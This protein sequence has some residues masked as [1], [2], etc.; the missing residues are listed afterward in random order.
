MP[1]GAVFPSQQLSLTTTVAQQ[2]IINNQGNRLISRMMKAFIPQKV[3]LH[4]K[5]LNILSS[6]AMLASK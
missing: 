5:L 1:T 6:W 3:F 4:Y 2:E